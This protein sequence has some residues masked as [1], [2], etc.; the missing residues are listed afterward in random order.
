MGINA[1]SCAVFGTPT[2]S[3]TFSVNVTVTDS[4]SP[5]KTASQ[6][7]SLTVS[8]AATA[9]LSI[10]TT[11]FNPSTATVGVGYAANA[12]VTATG[13]QAPYSCS[14]SGLPSGMG[15]NASSCAVFGTPTA[16][17][18]FSVNVTVTD[19][20]SPVKTASKALSLT[21]H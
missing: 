19:S 4:S 1:S 17:G 21:V 20:S 9:A 2:A 5:V 8:P 13:G 10:T 7:L 14:A 16:S 15:I 12:A 11:A 18:T 6:A 3:G